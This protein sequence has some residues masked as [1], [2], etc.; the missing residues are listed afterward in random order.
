MPILNYIV[1][2]ISVVLLSLLVSLSLFK[3]KTLSLCDCEYTKSNVI[4]S[5]YYSAISIIA[6]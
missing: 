3:Y 5:Y 6:M 1:Q 4:T 2:M